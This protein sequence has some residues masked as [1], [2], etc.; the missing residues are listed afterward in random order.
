MSASYF[1]FNWG[2]NMETFKILNVAFG[3]QIMGRTNV[4]EWFS[5]FNRSVTSVADVKNTEHSSKSTPE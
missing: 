3:Q 2:K 1:S 4:F 5:K